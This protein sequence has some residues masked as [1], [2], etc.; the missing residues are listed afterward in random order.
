MQRYLH[1]SCRNFNLVQLPLSIHYSCFQLRFVLSRPPQFDFV[2]QFS[3][4]PRVDKT[5]LLHFSRRSSFFLQIRFFTL[6]DRRS[7][8]RERSAFPVLL[9]WSM[10][11]FTQSNLKSR[12]TLSYASHS[13][14]FAF[15]K[16]RNFSNKGSKQEKSL[17]QI[18]MKGSVKF[19]CLVQSFFCAIA[20][21]ATRMFFEG[22]STYCLSLTFFSTQLNAA[23]EKE[24]FI[25]LKASPQGKNLI[26]TFFPHMALERVNLRELDLCETDR[27]DSLVH[28]TLNSANL[29]RTSHD[30]S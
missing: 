4:N 23:R 22:N 7:A 20:A 11:I 26:N 8:I 27:N 19:F 13:I 10:V 25:R 18:T 15:P 28:S 6:T 12:K 30:L 9:H 5:A 21:N 2:A 1:Y 29:L 14:S 16:R 17:G 24:A 3:C